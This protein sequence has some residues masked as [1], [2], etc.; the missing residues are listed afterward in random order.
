[1]LK[2]I[3]NEMSDKQMDKAEKELDM[4]NLEDVA[5][6]LA[7]EI[8]E[9]AMDY[10]SDILADEKNE[11]KTE[12]DFEYSSADVISLSNQL[13]EDMFVPDFEKFVKKYA[14]K[15]VLKK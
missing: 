3:V 7:K 10:Y 14:K 13:F 8:V 2:Q 4:Q 9:G 5:E 11:G 12:L 15:A 6:H 1:M